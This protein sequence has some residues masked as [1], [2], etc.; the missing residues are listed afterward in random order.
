MSRTSSRADRACSV[1][2]IAVY[3]ASSCEGPHQRWGKRC[4]TS[5]AG[6]IICSYCPARKWKFASSKEYHAGYT[7]LRR[8]A[9]STS[10]IPDAG[11]PA[12]PIT[13]EL[14]AANTGSADLPDIAGSR[15]RTAPA[16]ANY[17]RVLR[18]STRA[19]RFTA[20]STPPGSNTGNEQIRLPH[21]NAAA[22]SSS[23][24]WISALSIGPSR[25]SHQ[26][27]RL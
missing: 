4:D 15:S 7:G 9:R 20:A 17:L 13:C 19:M 1:R 11:S 3:A 23:G 25:R 27:T 2:P 24:Y 26:S 6:A 10:S 22:R 16:S 14:I 18:V 12:R 5:S 21:A 8:F